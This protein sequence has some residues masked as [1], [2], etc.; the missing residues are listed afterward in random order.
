MA[1]LTVAPET[2]ES[3]RL[4]AAWRCARARWELALY[5]PENCGD[6][7][8]DEDDTTFCD[9]EHSAL[10]EYLTAPA[11]DIKE[12]ARKLR[13]MKAEGGSGFTEA[14]AIISSLADSARRLTHL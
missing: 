14:E 13:V 2:T 12:L 1:D 3:Q 4:Y 9:A 11:E 7:L 5:S 8:S 10:I 6:D